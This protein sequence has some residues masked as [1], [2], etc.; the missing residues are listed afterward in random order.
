MSEAIWVS[1]GKK[2]Y[3]GGTITDVN[4]A[5]ISSATFQIGYSTSD[6]TPPSTWGTPD[7][8]TQ[9]A[10]TAIREVLLLVEDPFVAGQYYCWVD[11]ADSPEIEPLMVQRFTVA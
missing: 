2:R 6:S 9:G 7:V 11:V 8:S 4:G 10:T 3:V 5:D 1:L